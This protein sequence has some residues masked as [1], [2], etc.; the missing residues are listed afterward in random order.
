[1]EQNQIV[2]LRLLGDILKEISE[3]R[4]EVRSKLNHLEG[5]VSFISRSLIYRDFEDSVDELKDALE[6][7]ESLRSEFQRKTTKGGGLSPSELSG[8]FL[9][10]ID[11][12]FSLAVNKSNDYALGGFLDEEVESAE[13]RQNLFASE[14]GRI[15]GSFGLLVE[16][17]IGLNRRNSSLEI[18]DD[19]KHISQKRLPHPIFF[20]K[21][22]SAWLSS[23]IT[24]EQLDRS[25]G[26]KEANKK[27]LENLLV[28]WKICK[29]L[30][31]A[32]HISS[33][34]STIFHFVIEAL[35]ANAEFERSLHKR[36][37]R[38]ED[39]QSPTTKYLT[40]GRS[41]SYQLSPS[42]LPVGRYNN[43]QALTHNFADQKSGRMMTS[44]PDYFRRAV[45]SGVITI[46]LESDKRKDISE[47]KGYA[48]AAG[49]R[50]LPK[51]EMTVTP[52]K[53]KLGKTLGSSRSL[54][55]GATFTIY[56][57]NFESPL[58][59]FIS[60]DAQKWAPFA[61][62][63]LYPHNPNPSN[64]ELG[65]VIDHAYGQ[66]LAQHMQNVLPIK[67]Y[68]SGRS[69]R[70]YIKPSP[71]LTT[72][73]DI[74]SGES[75]PQLYSKE[76]ARFWYSPEKQ[77][78]WSVKDID[79]Q[80]DFNSLSD[81][82]DWVRDVACLND[83]QG[84]QALS[85][86]FSSDEISKVIAPVRYSHQRFRLCSAIKDW[87]NRGKYYESDIILQS[88]P[89]PGSLKAFVDSLV[90]G[91]NAETY[92]YFMEALEQERI[93]RIKSPMPSIEERRNSIDSVSMFS[94]MQLRAHI[95]YFVVKY[96]E[97]KDPEA[98]AK[99]LETP[100]F[101]KK[102]EWYYADFSS[103]EEE[104]RLYMAQV[105]ITGIANL[106]D[107]RELRVEF[108]LIKWLDDSDKAVVEGDMPIFPFGAKQE[109]WKKVRKLA[110][111]E[112]VFNKINEFIAISLRQNLSYEL[113]SNI[114][115]YLP[116]G[117][118]PMPD[119][120]EWEIPWFDVPSQVSIQEIDEKFVKN[121]EPC[122]P[123]DHLSEIP[124]NWLG[125]PYNLR[126]IIERTVR[127]R[128]DADIVQLLPSNL[129]THFKKLRH[130]ITQE[131][132]PYLK[133]FLD[134]RK[135]AAND[136]YQVILKAFTVFQSRPKIPSLLS[137]PNPDL[138]PWGFIFAGSGLGQPVV[139]IGFS[140]D[141]L[142]IGVFSE[143]LKAKKDI[144]DKKAIPEIDIIQ[145][146]LETLI[147]AYKVVA[148]SKDEK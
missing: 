117:A 123:Y 77:V 60:P 140:F 104:E 30:Q 31:I 89:S 24:R 57:F 37:T 105:V 121:G 61:D 109:T 43:P 110:V 148:L 124:W 32:G 12:L 56:L 75:F 83:S 82:M 99:H 38:N 48:R 3:G 101:V 116:S 87:R 125:G 102:G 20:A 141:E 128:M 5:K 74:N 126:A 88:L 73:V 55:A 80:G 115:K 142:A 10:N 35:Y 138:M 41:S 76:S 39:T 27:H 103:M 70:Y 33:R 29:D 135:P 16:Y 100:N 108:D 97:S 79:G 17:L 98:L 139:K 51:T 84:N 21:A 95:N 131:D 112:S 64:E 13:E 145:G 92:P 47:L 72:T 85:A 130:G 18:A 36:L 147:A 67:N 50:K 134:S 91:L 132:L 34:N 59:I 23:F 94:H 63:G 11:T 120:W 129:A 137:A 19:L 28:L 127:M 119:A 93:D 113:S 52:C 45:E 22:V 68:N 143:I 46:T 8:R 40:G 15:G 42:S 9:T 114:L 90:R 1:M 4:Y 71:V 78:F 53:V 2:A 106:P 44:I 144:K 133:L 6:S 26:V 66:V 54:Q 118:E 146:Q 25:S 81:F 14:L 49:S 58:K 7:S 62:H 96:L 65:Y 86:A 136:D 122:F 111:H 107:F 69:L